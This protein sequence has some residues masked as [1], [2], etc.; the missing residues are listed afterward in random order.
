M[1]HVNDPITINKTV[2]KNRLTMA[3][4]VKFKNLFVSRSNDALP[5]D[6][7]GSHQGTHD[8]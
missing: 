5:A 3:P 7:T 1:A 2:V 4:T 6:D 8:R